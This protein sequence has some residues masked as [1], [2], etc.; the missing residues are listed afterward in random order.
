M[1]DKKKIPFWRLSFISIAFIFITLVALWNS[2]QEPNAQMMG[3]SM[4][5][6]MKT[7]HLENVTIYDLFSNETDNSQMSEM[8]SHHQSQSSVIYN[9]NF[10]STAAIFLLLPFIIGGSIVLAIVWIK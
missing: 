2:P 10:I 4:G 5:N 9:F 8:Q 1:F 3:E 7:M 6:M